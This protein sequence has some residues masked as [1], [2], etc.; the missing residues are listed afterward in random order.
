MKH[1]KR[2]L[3]TQ[4]SYTDL[5]NFYT[6]QRDRIKKSKFFQINLQFQFLENELRDL[7]ALFSSGF[8]DESNI[9]NF[10]GK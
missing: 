7:K 6:K 1:I 4:K 2:Y 10:Y 5:I 3:R 8:K 9:I